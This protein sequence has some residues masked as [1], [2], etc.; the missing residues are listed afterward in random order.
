M[1]TA[2]K[3]H[4][5]SNR[6]GNQHPTDE[7]RRHAVQIGREV[8]AIAKVAGSAATEQMENVKDMVTSRAT[9]V[10]KTITSYIEERPIQSILMAAGAGLLVGMLW[11]RR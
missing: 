9:S 2:T 6:N 5:H 8:G 7:L 10:E 1:A 11:F 3:N 4:G